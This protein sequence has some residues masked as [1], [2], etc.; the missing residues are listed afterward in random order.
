Q[1]AEELKSARLAADA[2]NKAKSEFLATM[3]HEIR[4]PMNGI[5]GFVGLI[6]ETELSE[7]QR[8]HAETVREAA[9]NLL[10]LLN[11][12]LD[13]SRIEV[14]LTEFDWRVLALEWLVAGVLSILGETAQRKAV[15]LAGDIAS[16]VPP[17]L[18][19]D[20]H[21]LRQI[22]VNLVGNAVKFTEK[23]RID[24]R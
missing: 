13:Y 7:L 10:V 20:P 21:R 24:V 5:I 14:G 16:A 2:A 19:G 15:V 18:R 1:A 11:D 23:G 4:T 22:L 12:I 6:L 9:H 8:R 3:S 17:F